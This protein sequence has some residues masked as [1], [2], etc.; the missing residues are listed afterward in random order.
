MGAHKD[1]YER[2]APL[3]TEQVCSTDTRCK[4]Y[5]VHGSAGNNEPLSKK[6]EY[7][8]NTGFEQPE[9]SRIAM[10]LG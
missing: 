3:Y 10:L 2:L 9:R 1:Y 8:T 5:V 4:T 7:C 6:K